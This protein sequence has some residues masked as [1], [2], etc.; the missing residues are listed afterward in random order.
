M[1]F[2]KATFS[3]CRTTRMEMRRLVMS[4]WLKEGDLSFDMSDAVARS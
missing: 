2:R 3:Y 4:S 1:Q